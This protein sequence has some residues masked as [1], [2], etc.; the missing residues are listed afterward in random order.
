MKASY[1]DSLDTLIA[2]VT[3]MAMGK[4]THR[5]P[6]GL[7]KDASIDEAEIRRTLE[8][9]NGMFRKPSVP[10]SDGNPRYGL[11][12]R[13]AREQAAGRP[14][15]EDGGTEPLSTEDL[16]VLLNFVSERASQETNRKATL[17]TNWTAII[18]A[19]IAAAASLV[20]LLD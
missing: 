4:Y 3:Q 13:Y 11:H 9:F 20:N 1:S 8:A 12:L 18:V 6:A 10:S 5:T 16:T 17:W 7:S 19:G 2:L 14:Q 15:S